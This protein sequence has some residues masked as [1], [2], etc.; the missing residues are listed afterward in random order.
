[1]KGPSVRNGGGGDSLCGVLENRLRF[2]VNLHHGTDDT[3]PPLCGCLVG[4]GF[5]G[6]RTGFRFHMGL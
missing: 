4:C 1:M 3:D 2:A 6:F 5:C